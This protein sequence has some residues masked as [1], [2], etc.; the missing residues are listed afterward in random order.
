MNAQANKNETATPEIGVELDAK[1]DAELDA[2]ALEGAMPT[3]TGKLALLVA[4]LNEDERAVLSSIVTS[5][6]LHMQELQAINEN[7]EYLYAKPISAAATPNIREALLK[8]PTAL[9]FTE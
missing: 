5:S 9:G 6:S 2:A 7:A 8:L 1:L 3:L 4:D